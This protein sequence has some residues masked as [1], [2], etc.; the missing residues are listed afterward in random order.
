MAQIKNKSYRSIGEIS[1][2]PVYDNAYVF[3]I[4]YGDSYLPGIFTAVYS[5]KRTNPEADLVVMVTNDVSVE[6]CNKI[7]LVAT[8]LFYID[9]LSYPT[10]PLKSEKQK[11][12]YDSW[13][14]ESYTKWQMLSLPYKLAIF[15]DADVIVLQNID[16]LFNLEPPAGSFNSS[17]SKPLGPIHDFLVGARGLDGY[18]KHNEK[19]RP[20]IV[21]KILHGNSLVA[22]ASTILL[23]P[24][25]KDYYEYCSVMERITSKEP[26]GLRCASGV[27]EQSIC[28]FYATVKNKTF[29]N[30]HHRYNHM[31]RKNNYIVHTDYARVMHY[32]STNKPW[33]MKYNEWPDLICWY[34]IAAEGLSSTKL[35]ASDIKLNDDDV[36]LAKKAKDLY[37]MSFMQY[38]NK[39]ITNCLQIIKLHN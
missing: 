1:K 30:I 37:T 28:Y 39:K 36:S 9:Y 31:G 11:V 38:V 6:T 24:N 5:V 16:H 26:F 2:P 29:T 35:K 22:C 8:H 15:L 7:L 32:N 23:A 18:L 34:K 3:L 33:K 25:L 17:Y 21:K 13:I 14:S 19:I 27:D 4:M 10:K 12:H 20:N